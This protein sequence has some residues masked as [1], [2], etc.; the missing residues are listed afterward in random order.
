MSLLTNEKVSAELH[1]AQTADLDAFLQ[2]DH[3]V[4]M[5][6][7]K[8][9]HEEGFVYDEDSHP[10]WIPPAA[11][12]EAVFKFKNFAVLSIDAESALVSKAVKAPEKNKLLIREAIAS[13]LFPSLVDRLQENGGKLEL[14]A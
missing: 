7:K 8:L 5:E 4:K 9:L 2:M 1:L 11:R 10:I 14:F 12:F 6:L 13:G 3:F